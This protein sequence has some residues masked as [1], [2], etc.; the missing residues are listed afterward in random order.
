MPTRRSGGGFLILMIVAYFLML[1]LE[2]L[3]GLGILIDLRHFAFDDFVL[4]GIDADRDGQARRESA[5][6]GPR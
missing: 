3:L 5:S 6:R 4:E 1:P 2:K